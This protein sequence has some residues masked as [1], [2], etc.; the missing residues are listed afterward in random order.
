MAISYPI[1]R[2][3]NLWAIQIS[4]WF[5]M[6]P[7]GYLMVPSCPRRTKM[8]P[9]TDHPIEEWSDQELLDQYRYIAAELSQETRENRDR[10]NAP[11]DVLVEEIRR[12]G[13]DVPTEP[14]LT[15]P[16]REVTQEGIGEQQE[17]DTGPV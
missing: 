14:S 8:N 16:G 4:V 1:D 5:R 10:D 17:P 7:L 12:R 15:I 6:V 3:A 11:A 13:L 2:T 9:G